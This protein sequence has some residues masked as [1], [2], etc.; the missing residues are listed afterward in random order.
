MAISLIIVG[1]AE[2]QTPNVIA[3]CK[4]LLDSS[5]S[6]DKLTVNGYSLI[7]RD[8]DSHGRSI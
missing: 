2:A 6:S 4:T 5:I 1:Q 8:R 7:R 3:L